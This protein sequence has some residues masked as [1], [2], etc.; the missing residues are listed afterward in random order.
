MDHQNSRLTDLSWVPCEWGF[1]C[2]SAGKESA[3]N[4]GDLGSIPGL[5]RCSWERNGYHTPVFWPGEFHGLY[6]PWGCKELDTNEQLS[7]ST[8][9]RV[10]PNLHVSTILVAELHAVLWNSAVVNRSLLFTRPPSCHQNVAMGPSRVTWGMWSIPPVRQ[11]VGECPEGKTTGTK[12]HA[13]LSLA[14]GHHI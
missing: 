10:T 7:L 6:S 4:V 5:G 1:P 11:W 9:V 3:C 13:H 14:S 12:P 8:W 2:G